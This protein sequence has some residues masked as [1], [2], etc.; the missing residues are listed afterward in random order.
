M[1]EL[2]SS[3]QVCFFLSESIF[4]H[5]TNFGHRKIA[6]YTAPCFKTTFLKKNTSA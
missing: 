5:V 6:L 3:P 1:G 4:K 2:P